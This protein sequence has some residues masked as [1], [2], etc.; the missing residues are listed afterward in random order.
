MVTASK[1]TQYAP[2]L[3]LGPSFKGMPGRV[4]RVRRIERF[5]LGVSAVA[6]L[7]IMF[8][9]APYWAFRVAC[10]FAGF[11][12]A[13]GAALVNDMKPADGGP[14]SAAWGVLAY[15]GIG[16]GLVAALWN[17]EQSRQEFLYWRYTFTRPG[18]LIDL[19]HDFAGDPGRFNQAEAS[20]RYPG[21]PIRCGVVEPEAPQRAFGGDYCYFWTR[22]VN[23]LPGRMTDFVFERETLNAVRLEVPYWRT[24]RHHAAMVAAYGRPMKTVGLDSLFKA[25]GG[26][27]GALAG[28]V[29]PDISAWMLPAGV[30]MMD[31]NV[32]PIHSTGLIF[33]VSKAHFCAHAKDRDSAD[34]KHYCG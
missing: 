14:R 30:L 10:V 33:W 6:V 17:H 9:L 1:L 22:S 28:L 20:R 7:A 2:Y 21:A 8:L 4:A 24:G 25:L 13:L 3:G 5:Y 19:R 32:S 15:C 23:G 12:V 31:A 16:L 11:Y 29:R 18:E 27:P 34:M 26:V